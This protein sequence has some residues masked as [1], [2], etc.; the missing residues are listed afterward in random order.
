MGVGASFG[1]A[2]PTG[3]FVL[4]ATASN[5]SGTSPESSAVT[6]TV[7]QTA[8]QPPGAPSNLAATVSGTTV[9]FTWTAPA[10]GGLV[11]SYVLVAGLTPATPTTPRTS[12]SAAGREILS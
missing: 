12:S 6:V 7:P 2:A 10:S 8:T 3:T 4:T 1:V 5:A 11:E 9:N